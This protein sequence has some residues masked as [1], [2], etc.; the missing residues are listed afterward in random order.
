MYWSF[1]PIETEFKSKSLPTYRNAWAS[2]KLKKKNSTNLSKNAISWCSVSTLL[3]TKLRYV[4]NFLHFYPDIIFGTIW[5]FI[6][7]KAG[8]EVLYPE[9]YYQTASSDQQVI[10]KICKAKC[11]YEGPSANF[12]KHTLESATVTKNVNLLNHNH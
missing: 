5:H 3:L 11:K 2:L 12:Q 10:L 1:F 6:E 8:N 9:L 4:F 7:V